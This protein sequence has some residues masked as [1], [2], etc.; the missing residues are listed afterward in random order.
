LDAVEAEFS[1]PLAEVVTGTERLTGLRREGDGLTVI[2]QNRL[3]RVE[4]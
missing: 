1:K 2:P 3:V 4:P